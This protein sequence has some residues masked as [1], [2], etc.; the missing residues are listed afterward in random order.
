MKNVCKKLLRYMAIMYQKIKAEG[1]NETQ[2]DLQWEKAQPAQ[3]AYQ[4]NVFRCS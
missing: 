1:V 2:E 3:G 4:K